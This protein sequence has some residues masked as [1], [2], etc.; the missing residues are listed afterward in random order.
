M[1]KK[2]TVR[3][4]S[5]IAIFAALGFALDMAQSG[6]FKGFFPNGGSIGIAMV[7]IFVMCFRRGFLCGLLTGF[8][9][10]LTQMLGGI[11]MIT[12]TWYKAFA[13]VALDYWLAYPVCAIAGLFKILVDKSNST[14][15]KNMWIIIGCVIGGLGKYLCHYLSGILFWPDDL[16]NVGGPYIFSLLYNGAY[17]IPCIILCTLLMFLIS[18]KYPKFLIPNDMEVM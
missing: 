6:L 10:G 11:C 2:L 5:E 12:D 15:R 17:M 18:W 3:A 8:I 1:K 16:W 4:I 13:Q 14:T 9:M 7:A